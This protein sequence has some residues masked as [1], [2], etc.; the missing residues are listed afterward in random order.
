M[1]LEAEVNIARKLGSEALA[2]FA[3]LLVESQLIVAPVPDAAAR[4]QY[5]G[6]AGEKDDHVVAAAVAVHAA[7]LLTLDRRLR[8]GVN[9]G[10]ISVRALTPGEFITEILPAHESF[11]NLRIE[12]E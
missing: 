7:Y 6:L 5:R 2:S 10:S 9:A 1:L 12:S 11:A 4:E 8:E 3:R